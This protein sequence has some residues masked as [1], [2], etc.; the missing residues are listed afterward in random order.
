MV[1]LKKV[2]AKGKSDGFPKK[3]P[4]LVYRLKSIAGKLNCQNIV[5]TLTASRVVDKVILQSSTVAQLVP[6]FVVVCCPI[7]STHWVLIGGALIKTLTTSDMRTVR[8][9]DSKAWTVHIKARI[10]VC[11]NE[12]GQ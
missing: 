5:L 3:R 7:R 1:S 8:S 10:E 4:P 11:D 2:C 12:K 6:A 9:T